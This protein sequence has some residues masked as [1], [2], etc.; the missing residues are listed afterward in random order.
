M[1]KIKL[2]LIGLGKMGLPLA[3]K[4]NEK[5][6]IIV[7]DNNKEKLKHAKKKGLSIA[8]GINE[9]ITRLDKP[10]IIWIMVPPGKQVDNIIEDIKDYLKKDD[11]IIDGGNSNYLDTIDR[12]IYLEDIDI[13]FIGLGISGGVN[14][15]KSSPPITLDSDK[16][17]LKK[18]LPLL[19]ILGRNYVCYDNAGKGHLSKTI[20]NAIEYG[21]MQS[22]AEGV[23]LYLKHGFS[24]NEIK[25]TFKVWGNGS[26]IES[27]LVR[28]LN[29][30]LEKNSLF[31]KKKISKSETVKII[32][33][34]LNKGFKTPIIKKCV[35]LRKNNKE[36]DEIVHTI[37]A[38]MRNRFGGHSLSKV[39]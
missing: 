13:K 21:M 8:N 20:H 31:D 30:I 33:K 28:I 35:K 10:C 23:F 17:T 18:V 6:K 37:L 11:L 15:I 19:N 26:I 36:L 32:E 16:K 5:R 27:K 7:F 2:G 4:F 24:E 25:E 1:S 9:F 39:K 29:E 38:R 22:I 34:V 12:K 14:Q 3:L